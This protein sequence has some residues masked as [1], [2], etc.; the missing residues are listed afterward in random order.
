M[1]LSF[2]T[3]I[4]ASPHKHDREIYCNAALVWYMYRSTAVHHKPGMAGGRGDL[5]QCR[6]CSVH[7]SY[8]MHQCNHITDMAGRQARGS[9]VLPFS[10]RNYLRSAYLLSY[11]EAN[12]VFVW[13]YQAS[14]RSVH[15]LMRNLLHR[16]YWSSSSK[17]N[18]SSS[19]LTGYSFTNKQ[20]TNR[21][22]RRLDGLEGAS[23][24]WVVL[25]YQYNRIKRQKEQKKQRWR[26]WQQQE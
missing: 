9:A 26:D 23:T 2:R 21:E 6:S 13:P 16:F 1:P 12:K 7:V 22:K 17:H 8:I 19:D 25:S 3:W 20:T 11:G 10:F 24:R 14:L 4:I 5:L 18:A 15:Q